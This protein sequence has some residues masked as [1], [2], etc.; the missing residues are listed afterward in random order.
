MKRMNIILALSF[1]FSINLV[2]GQ[3]NPEKSKFEVI[4]FGGLGFTKVKTDIQARYDLNVNTGEILFNY[5]I[6]GKYGIASGIGYSQLSGSGFNKTGPFYADREL[7][8]IPFLFTL[9]QDISERLF[10]IGNIGPY[11]QTITKDRLEYIGFG[12]SDVYEGWNFG[13]Q[14]GVGFGFKIDQKVGI[15]IN[16]NGQSD[17]SKLDTNAGKSFADKQRHKNLNSIGLF[18][19]YNL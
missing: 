6:W 4:A 10:L 1:L 13:V 2:H 19:K 9:N 17:L 14:L 18:F 11:A 7:L 12:E 15:G 16:Y 5:K 8:K 3:D